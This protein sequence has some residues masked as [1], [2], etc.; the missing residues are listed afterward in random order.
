M[1]E[2]PKKPTIDERLE[3]LTMHLE[4]L[5]DSTRDL[6]A[7]VEAEIARDRKRDERQKEREERDR[8]YLN[9]IGDVL[10]HWANGIEPG[11]EESHA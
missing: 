6:R 1:P 5:S 8:K 4:L 11:N 2:P 3:A 10:K 7:V 9:A